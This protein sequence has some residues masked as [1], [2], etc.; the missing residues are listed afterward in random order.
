MK[1]TTTQ[2]LRNHTH[3][4]VDDADMRQEE[5]KFSSTMMKVRRQEKIR[6]TE[7]EN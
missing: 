4:T 7:T 1:R 5:R 3:I 6:K 2:K